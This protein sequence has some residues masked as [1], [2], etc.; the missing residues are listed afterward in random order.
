MPATLPAFPLR[1][2]GN[3][4]SAPNS[5][6]CTGNADPSRRSTW[7]ARMTG[8]LGTETLRLELAVERAALPHQ[9]CIDLQPHQFGDLRW[10]AAWKKVT[11]A[12]DSDKPRRGN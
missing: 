4:E 6:R 1:P 8:G 2:K 7:M 5:W 9:R 12:F 11:P 3:F 10:M